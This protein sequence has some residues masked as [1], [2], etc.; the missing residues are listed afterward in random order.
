MLSGL[1]AFEASRS[2]KNCT[3][4]SIATS[5]VISKLFPSLSVRGMYLDGIEGEEKV[6]KSRGY[7][8]FAFSFAVFAVTPLYVVASP[9]LVRR[10][11]IDLCYLQN[12]L[13]LSHNEFSIL[14]RYPW[15][16]IRIR[17][18]IFLSNAS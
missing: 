1:H 16:L 8:Y 3:T 9:W 13:G 10:W 11:R 4:L 6:R 18:F 2:R 12:I 14:P 5:S 17:Y 15:C 7:K